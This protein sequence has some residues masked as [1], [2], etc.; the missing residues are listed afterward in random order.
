MTT[1]K[2]MQPTIASTLYQF[3]A[4]FF[5]FFSRIAAILPLSSSRKH[6]K[7]FRFDRSSDTCPDDL[8]P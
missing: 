7:Q 8:M 6:H 4:A 1:A 5:C 2:N 3:F